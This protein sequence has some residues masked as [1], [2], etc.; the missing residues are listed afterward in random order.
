M[1]DEYKIE[2]YMKKIKKVLTWSGIDGIISIVL[3]FVLDKTGHG[4]N[5]RRGIEV[6]ITRRS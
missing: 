6:V 3:S 4:V 2:I 5:I 1:C